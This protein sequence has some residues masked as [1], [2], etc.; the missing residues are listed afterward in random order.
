MGLAKLRV[1]NYKWNGRSIPWPDECS[2]GFANQNMYYIIYLV[3]TLDGLTKTM[4]F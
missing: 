3:R 2:S 1:D 4:N